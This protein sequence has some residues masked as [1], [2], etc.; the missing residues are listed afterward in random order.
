MD[1]WTGRVEP[2]PFVGYKGHN[3]DFPGGSEAMR[4]CLLSIIATAFSIGA[5]VA[6]ELPADLAVIDGHYKACMAKNPDNAGLKEC[7]YKARLEADKLLT[8]TY[9]SIQAALRTTQ[10]GASESD[11]TK[12]ELN[13]C[14]LRKEFGLPIGTRNVTYKEYKCWVEAARAW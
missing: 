1:R 6:E 3:L 13:A 5:A 14:W 11:N 4:L 8:N 12:E 9:R 7:T 2:P 10:P